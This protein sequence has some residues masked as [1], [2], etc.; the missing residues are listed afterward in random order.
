MKNHQKVE[1]KVGIFSS[2]I[3][4]LLFFSINIFCQAPFGMRARDESKRDIIDSA[5]MKFTYK[6][7]FLPDTTKRKEY[8][9]NQLILLIGKNVSKFDSPTSK[10]GLERIAANKN[11]DAV[12]FIESRG[13]AGTEVYKY[14]QTNK[15][16]VTT[17]IQALKGAYIYEEPI[18]IQNWFITKERKQILS[19]D[20]QKAETFF[21][22]RKYEAWFSISIPISNGPWKFGGLPGLILAVSDTQH[23]YDFECIGIK[24]LKAKEPIYKYKWK[25]VK[26]TRANYNKVL[27]NLH[28]HP[29]PTLESMGLDFISDS[30][31]ERNFTAPYNPIEFK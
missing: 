1:M 26:T 19:Y 31:S 8:V 22:G 24:S 13:L 15:E 2:L 18:P 25:Y 20:C 7:T 28:L 17:R 27:R 11:R 10:E 9:T 5:F 12:P 16:V 21:H 23:Y 3:M 29:V 4:I 30:P 14:F 6:L